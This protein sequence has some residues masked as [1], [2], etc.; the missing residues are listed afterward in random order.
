MT[1]LLAGIGGLLGAN[2]IPQR[3]IGVSIKLAQNT[4]TNQPTTFAGLGSSGGGIGALGSGGLSGLISASA[5]GSQ[6]NILGLRVSAR[7][8]NAGAL[9]TCTVKIWGLP[10]S[11]LNQLNSLGMRLNII[12]GNKLTVSAG[13][14]STALSPVFYG[15]ILYGSADY[16][17]QPDVPLTIE[18]SAGTP[19][20]ASTPTSFPQGFSVS[21][22]MSNLAGKMGLSFNN[23]GNIN[24]QLP[25]IYL[26][27]S[28][29]VQIRKL[30]QAAG[31]S[32]GIS[33]TQALEIFQKGTPRKDGSVIVISKQTGMIASPTFSGPC[34]VVKTLF[35]PNI[36]QSSPIQIQSTV[37]SA[38]ANLP[39][40]QSLSYSPISTQYTVQQIDLELEAQVP[41]GQWMMT[42]QGYP[43]GT[44][45]VLPSAT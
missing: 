44:N 13:N 9:P 34:I 42:L 23:A 45:P 7:V 4:Q 1:D 25:P 5:G 18:A 28:P 20:L 41:K 39:L 22:A 21:E 36:K 12:T 30:A 14:S 17:N 11:I 10:P 35:N 27:G 26:S 19:V 31:I 38:V 3:Q 6:L 8:R 15:D 16:D 32:F 43:A 2:Q 29:L 33:P 24:I 40:G 37:L